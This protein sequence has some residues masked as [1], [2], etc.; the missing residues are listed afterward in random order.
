MT[1][2]TCPTD[3][4]VVIA[5]IA[6]L[7]CGKRGFQDAWNHLA[8]FL[9]SK[10][11]PHYVLVTGDLV[12]SPKVKNLKLVLGCLDNLGIDY[13]I[14]PGNH[15]RFRW[16]NRLGLGS[17]SPHLDGTFGDRVCRTTPRTVT[18]SS[19]SGSAWCIGVA[20]LD[21]ASRSDGF[22]R[23][24]AP[25]EALDELEK[26]VCNSPDRGRWDLAVVLAHHHPQSA[27]ALEERRRRTF[28]GLI[29]VMALINSGTFLE[30]IARLGFDVVLHGHEHTTHWSRYGSLEGERCDFA[31]VGA[32][33]ATGATA[34]SCD[35]SRA[36]L[37][38]LLLRSDRSV[39]FETVQYTSDGWQ[40]KASLCLARHAEMRRRQAVRRQAAGAALGVE[41][42]LL[43]HAHITRLR[44]TIVTRV[45][46]NVVVTTPERSLTLYWAVGEIQDIRVDVVGPDGSRMECPTEMREESAPEKQCELSWSI[47]EHL[48]NTCITECVS[49]KTIGNAV[50]TADEVQM[51]IN[52]GAATRFEQQG[53]AFQGVVGRED[54][55]VI[56]S[57]L[58]LPPEYDPDCVRAVVWD[59]NN[60]EVVPESRAA[61]SILRRLGPGCYSLRIPIVRGGWT[62]F[63]VWKPPALVLSPETLAW[64]EV[65]RKHGDAILSTASQAVSTECGSGARM[66]ILVRPLSDP[67]LYAELVTN[68]GGRQHQVSLSLRGDL[69][70]IGRAFGGATIIGGRDDAGGGGNLEVD[71]CARAVVPLLVPGGESNEPWSV[72]RIGLTD[73][74]AQLA[75]KIVDG[76]REAWSRVVARVAS[77]VVMEAAKLRSAS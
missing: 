7:H 23:G 77:Q 50:L 68:V 61:T 57:M 60:K 13:L 35:L 70:D 38:L 54:L 32:G 58:S 65:A 41:A 4:D 62:Y 59:A 72:L 28:G 48:L 44:D 76:E 53:E 10:V 24:Y 12:D 11:R 26:D 45:E 71:E 15:D 66:W 29:E 6:D 18:V 5:H 30:R 19:R 73:S 9:Q 8:A 37:N 20:A 3:D 1:L 52:D 42:T 63:L 36:S 51:R 21:T 64:Q 67:R 49:Y 31:V 47:P 17:P 33:S 75:K 34:G 55:P 27:R 16:G 46:R 39:D 56:D 22:A 69:S 74:S 40:V 43:R 14:C 25:P 2:W